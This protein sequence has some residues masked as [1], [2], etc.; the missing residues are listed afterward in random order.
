MQ[1]SW[2]PVSVADFAF[3]CLTFS[4][5]PAEDGVMGVR[6]RPGNFILRPYWHRRCAF[7][8]LGLGLVLDT[9]HTVRDMQHRI[10]SKTFTCQ[11]AETGG[12]E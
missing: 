3:A 12:V 1:Q 7:P 4:T 2:R 10:T 8:F 11:R 9:M 6:K 5:S